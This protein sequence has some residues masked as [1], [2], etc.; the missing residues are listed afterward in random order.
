MLTE[1][2]E[3]RFLLSLFVLIA[4]ACT[5]F[6]QGGVNPKSDPTLSQGPVLFANPPSFGFPFVLG[7]NTP[8]SSSSAW[9]TQ[10]TGTNAYSPVAWPSTSCNCYGGEFYEVT[11]QP[12]PTAPLVTVTVPGTWGWAA[13]M[14]DAPGL[15]SP[16]QIPIS[17]GVDGQPAGCIGGSDAPVMVVLGTNL[18]NFWVFCRTGT[19][20]ATADAFAVCDL[21]NGTGWSEYPG[22]A[23]HFCGI[24]GSASS[25]LAGAIFPWEILKGVIPHALQFVAVGANCPV[26]YMAPALNTDCFIGNTAPIVYEGQHFAIPKTTQV[27]AG[28]SPIGKMMFTALQNYGAYITD[29]GGTW[30]VRGGWAL[31]Q[32][33]QLAI[34][35]DWNVLNP[36]LQLV[37]AAPAEA[38]NFPTYPSFYYGFRCVSGNDNGYYVADIWDA[39]TGSTTETQITCSLGVLN[40]TTPNPIA[41]TC[42]SG[43][44][45]KSL[46]NQPSGSA[47]TNIATQATNANRPTYTDNC[48]NGHPCMACTASTSLTVASPPTITQGFTVAAVVERTGNFTTASQWFNSNSG[49]VTIGFDAVVNQVTMN[50]GG[51]AFVAPAAD[52]VWHSFIADVNG[53]VDIG[54]W[55]VDGA[56]LSVAFPSIGTNVPSGSIVLCDG[57][58]GN[59]GSVAGWSASDLSITQATALTQTDLWWF[60]GT[61]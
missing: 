42:A 31:T 1:Q 4:S 46:Y 53:T 3:M 25:G 20:T 58:T 8:F 34:Y 2:K 48:A 26:G 9:N 52:S 37:N 15:P 16:G 56:G 18:Y 60:T 17:V 30:V 41:T 55:W 61:P 24:N 32:S 28:L 51:T 54:G 39:A 59:F 50:A 29:N 35:S 14:A 36:M 13:N 19:N 10:I 40:K 44:R 33:Q 23:G 12:A 45:V 38:Y 43:C 47:T 11:D 49:A 57:M 7:V 6:A 5:A 21:V 27:P 22:M